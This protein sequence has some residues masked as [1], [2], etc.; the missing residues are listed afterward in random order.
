MGVGWRNR[1]VFSQGN[2]IVQET[3]VS[4]NHSFDQTTILHEISLSSNFSQ[5]MI[6][7]ESSFSEFQKT[8]GV[9]PESRKTT[10]ATFPMDE[11]AEVVLLRL[12]ASPVFGVGREPTVSWF[13][14]GAINAPD[15]LEKRCVTALWRN[16]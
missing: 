13:K 5:A 2:V 6:L 15:M 4:L 11:R 8:G 1:E 12:R 16:A 14:A 10:G 7:W 3:E 9:L